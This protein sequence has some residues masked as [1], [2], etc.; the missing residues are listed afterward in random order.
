MDDTIQLARKIEMKQDATL[1]KERDRV[2][3]VDKAAQV[4]AAFGADRGSGV[5]SGKLTLADVAAATG[6]SRAAARRYVLTL[7]HLGFVQNHGKLYSLTPKVLE[8]GQQYCLAMSRIPTYQTLCRQLSRALGEASS[9]TIL[10]HHQAISVAF[11]GADQFAPVWVRSGQTLPAHACA[12]GRL[13]LSNLDDTSITK[14]L[15]GQTFEKYTP[16]S[17]AST[18]EVLAQIAV[19]RELGFACDDQEIEMGVRSIAIG[20]KNEHGSVV[21]ALNLHI[22]MN[23]VGLGDMVQSMLPKMRQLQ[24][25][26][27]RDVF[28]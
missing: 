3:G 16:H 23:R 17:L 7:L 19:A 15:K 5:R 9:V 24:S 6:L 4:V 27:G 11:N 22:G 13:L 10:H 12:A 2:A 25:L 20:L 8:L 18:S 14:A 28:E 1:I 26:S 21:A